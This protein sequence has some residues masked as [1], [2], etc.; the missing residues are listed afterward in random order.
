MHRLK[1]HFIIVVL[2][3][4]Y[5]LHTNSV[6]KLADQN[7]Y[8]SGVTVFHAALVMLHGL[9]DINASDLFS[10]ARNISTY[11]LKKTST[12]V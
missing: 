2:N 3:P 5:G 9:V 12:V 7:I 11:F 10:L 8:W 6:K 4:Y 1:T